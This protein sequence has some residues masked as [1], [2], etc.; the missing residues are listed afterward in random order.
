MYCCLAFL[1]L[2]W[3]PQGL[4]NVLDSA[5]IIWPQSSSSCPLSFS[6]YCNNNKISTNHKLVL[7]VCPEFLEKLVHPVS[8]WFFIPDSSEHERY[9][10]VISIMVRFFMLLGPII[11]CHFKAKTTIKQ[12][13]TLSVQWQNWSYRLKNLKKILWECPS[14]KSLTRKVDTSNVSALTLRLLLFSVS[15]EH[16]LM[17][18]R[19]YQGGSFRTDN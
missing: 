7:R 13:R 9:I 2:I 11:N 8:L 18:L 17:I 19:V 3:S 4:N 6:P 10:S 14:W 15:V 5:S 1:S 16:S 12:V